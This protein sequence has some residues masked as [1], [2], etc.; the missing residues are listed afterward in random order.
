[1]TPEGG[2]AAD[3][4]RGPCCPRCPRCRVA[5]VLTVRY[6]HSWHNRAGERVEGVAE[7]LLCSRCDTDDPAAA[8]LLAL[9]GEGGPTGAAPGVFEERAGS[10][11]G[12]V[13]ARRADPG[14]LAAEEGRWRAGE[15]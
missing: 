5:A 6:P 12:A 13:R 1:M 15:L 8:A 2:T 14:A 11:L 3:G 10:W 9:L 4:T 7:S